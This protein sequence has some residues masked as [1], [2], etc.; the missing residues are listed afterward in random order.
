MFDDDSNTRHWFFDRDSHDAGGSSKKKARVEINV[1][2]ELDSEL[3]E[4]DGTYRMVEDS[5]NGNKTKRRKR[6]M[7]KNEQLLLPCSWGTC[8]LQEKSLT[9]FIRH[10]NS[11]ISDTDVREVDGMTVYGCLW[12]SCDFTTAVVD[13]AR[14]HIN[15]HA[16]HTKLKSIGMS[17]KARS[18][19]PDCLYGDSNAN[20]IPDLMLESYKCCWSDCSYEG[21][22]IQTFFFHVTAHVNTCLSSEDYKCQW[23]GCNNDF[24]NLNKLN[25]HVRVHTKEKL[26]ACPDCG[27]M[28]ASNTK[29][30]DHCKRQLPLDM[31]GYQCAHCFKYYSSERILRDHM[32][33][34]INVHKCIYCDMT[35][36]NKFT[37][38]AHIRFRHLRV[39]PFNCTSCNYRCETKQDLVNH[40]RTHDNK[41]RLNCE[42]AD[43]N[44][45]CRSQQTMKKHI[46]QEHEGVL[47]PYRI[48][49]CH[50]CGK[51]FTRGVQ[52]TNHLKSR[53]NL[54]WP[55]GHKRFSYR[56]DEDG[57][58]K[59]QRIRYE[60][61]D[62]TEQMTSNNSNI[63]DEEDAVE[64]EDDP[65]PKEDDDSGKKVLITIDE[66]NETGKKIVIEYSS[67]KPIGSIPDGATVLAECCDN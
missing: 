8:E 62:V 55:S 7:M 14:R 1:S 34:H 45:T 36:A 33:S 12:K 15:Y 32:R 35:C 53:H 17:V 16:Y 21:S 38:A 24:A 48:Y 60:S 46:L 27:G 50:E 25:C 20:Q 65:K 5:N 42:E 2:Q 31:Q 39:R 11:H 22:C 59:L 4:C 9:K 29:F 67:V 56:P 37:L 19:L 3:S 10:V 47:F 63:S 57:K 66:I 23:K 41:Y 40:L 51:Q 44:F 52:L 6:V 26:V 43:C 28:F 64:N 30:I 13:E 61:L 18:D 49:E 54:H 58:Y